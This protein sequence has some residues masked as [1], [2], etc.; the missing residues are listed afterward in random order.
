MGLTTRIL[1]QAIENAST[2][3]EWKE[4][5]QIYD[6]T[7]RQ[8]PWLTASPSDRRPDARHALIGTQE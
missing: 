2:Y 3:D 6:T 1:E 5:V 7:C 8:L 4:G